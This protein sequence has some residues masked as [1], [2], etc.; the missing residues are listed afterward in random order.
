L[1]SPIVKFLP[2]DAGGDPRRTGAQ[3][4]DLIFGATGKI[5][6]DALG[7]LRA[8]VGHDQASPPGWK[9]MWVVDFPMFEYDAER[10]SW[11]A[12][13]HPFTAPKDGHE[14]LFD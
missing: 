1:Q 4:G 6:S 11:A 12:R 10:R 2:A 5:V 3:T 7:A 14:D 9:P 8:K 13:H